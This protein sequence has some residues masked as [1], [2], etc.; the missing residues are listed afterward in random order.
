MRASDKIEC[1]V[2]DLFNLFIISV[3]VVDFFVSFSFVRSLA[4]MLSASL[5]MSMF[6]VGER[7]F[8]VRY[9]F[10]SCARGDDAVVKRVYSAIAVNAPLPDPCTENSLRSGISMYAFAKYKQ[11]SRARYVP[12]VLA[13]RLCF[14]FAC[15]CV[16]IFFHPRTRRGFHRQWVLFVFVMHR[17]LFWF[18]QRD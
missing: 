15:L 12:I 14:F 8:F 18:A 10:A 1:G 9:A 6:A 16:C 11:I 3:Y 4:R 2:V 7:F 13:S 17:L 5:A